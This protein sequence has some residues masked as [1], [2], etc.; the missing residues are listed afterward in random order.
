MKKVHA[1]ILLSVLNNV[2]TL[3]LAFV[4][5]PL[6]AWAAEDLGVWSVGLAV[7]PLGIQVL[8]LALL[9][10]RFNNKYALKPSKFWQCAALPAVLISGVGA[11]IC[12]A[13]AGYRFEMLLLKIFPLVM[14]LYSAVFSAVLAITLKISSVKGAQQ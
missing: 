11:I 2:L 3:S 6:L 8:V 5:F 14:L 4:G 9:Q 1:L 10:K 7:V 13:V 12:S